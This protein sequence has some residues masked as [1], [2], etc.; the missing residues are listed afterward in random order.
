MV[1]TN[2]NIYTYALALNEAFADETQKLP[3]KI[4]FYLQK[5]KNTLISL[6]QDIEMAR[7]EII[8]TYG[9]ISED[10]N[11]YSMSPGKFSQAQQEMSDLLSLEQDVQI[12][13]I[14]TE[15]LTNDISLTTAQME[16]MLFMIE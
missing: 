1:L 2:Q 14:S 12:Y 4:N 7:M 11:N 5:N 15:A 13:M 10:G 3:M 9:V 8:K 6:A 16:A